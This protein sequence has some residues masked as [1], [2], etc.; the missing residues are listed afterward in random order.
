MLSWFAEFQQWLHG[1]SGGPLQSLLLPV[2]GQ[3]AGR[4]ETSV[5]EDGPLC[6][7]SKLEVKA[8]ALTVSSS[9]SVPSVAGR[10][11]REEIPLQILFT[12]SFKTKLV[13]FLGIWIVLSYSWKWWV[14]VLI[15]CMIL[16]LKYQISV[17]AE[18]GQVW[19]G[20]SP[21]PSPRTPAAAGRITLR[22][23]V[24]SML[25]QKQTNTIMFFPQCHNLQNKD[26]FIVLEV[27]MML[28]CPKIC[29]PW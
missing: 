23:S 11:R 17:P 21:S 22:Y 14:N 10:R 26:K 19:K 13:S 27:L 8:C 9:S 6:R 18:G 20:S 12:R 7:C 2:D 1:D 16:R 25:W 3:L 5:V 28:I 24:V 15:Q 4:R 29:L